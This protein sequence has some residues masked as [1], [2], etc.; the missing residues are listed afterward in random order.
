M[1]KGID[2]TKDKKRP[3]RDRLIGSKKSEDGSNTTPLETDKKPNRIREILMGKRMIS[4][5]IDGW[6]ND[7]E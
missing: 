3:L 1:D 2:V 6:G 5:R 7:D 4:E